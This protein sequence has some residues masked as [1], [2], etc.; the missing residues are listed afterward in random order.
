MQLRVQIMANTFQI[1]TISNQEVGQIS[2]KSI[3]MAMSNKKRRNPITKFLIPPVHKD[4]DEDGW[5]KYENNAVWYGIP[6]QKGYQNSQSGKYKRYR[7]PAYDHTK[8]LLGYVPLSS[9]YVDAWINLSK[10]VVFY[11]CEW[12]LWVAESKKSNSTVPEDVILELKRDT[13]TKLFQYL[14]IRRMVVEELL[15]AKVDQA[16]RQELQIFDEYILRETCYWLWISLDEVPEEERMWLKLDPVD[17]SNAELFR[18]YSKCLGH[19]PDTLLQ[20]LTTYPQRFENA[21]KNGSGD[22]S[23]TTKRDGTMTCLRS[24]SS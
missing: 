19:I 20:P 6:E 4:L 2:V 3:S 13:G 10:T 14:T 15:R 1:P 8:N 11:L 16:G 18:T 21:A 12:R 17:K 9:L 23:K 24:P 22:P 5:K 7:I